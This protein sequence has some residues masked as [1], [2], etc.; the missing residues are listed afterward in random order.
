MARLTLALL[1]PTHMALDG[2]TANGLAYAKVRAASL[3]GVGGP[4]AP[5]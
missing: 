5:A 4:T 3:P 2:Q 1:G